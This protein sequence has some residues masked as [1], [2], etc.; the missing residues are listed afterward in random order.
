L[1]G[2]YRFSALP[3]WRS[4]QEQPLLFLSERNYYNAKCFSEFAGLNFVVAEG[5]ER[6][7]DVR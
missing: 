6:G 4:L 3:K 2:H 7:S 5:D 1:H